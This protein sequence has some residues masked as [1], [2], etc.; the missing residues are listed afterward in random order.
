[1]SETHEEKIQNAKKAFNRASRHEDITPYSSE[2]LLSL[3][4]SAGDIN[5]VRR[6]LKARPDTSDAHLESALFDAAE[7]GH[8]EI[9]NY[10]IEYGGDFLIHQNEHRALNGAYNLAIEGGFFKTAD[11]L[12]KNGADTKN[13]DAHIYMCASEVLGQDVLNDMLDKWDNKK[14][15]LNSTHGMP[16][17]PLQYQNFLKPDACGNLLV[18]KL[19]AHGYI[20]ELF[21]MRIWD[22]HM[23]EA[24]D[25]WTNYVPAIYKHQFDFHTAFTKHLNIQKVQGASSQ[26]PKRRPPAPK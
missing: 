3:A 9:V 14:T 19:C 17:M 6:Y 2:V 13:I 11:I 15:L 20:K 25:I 18:E 26:R 8:Q 12:F 1:M 21:D 23:D 24:L 16:E 4:V 10:L 7:M 5:Y 22:Q